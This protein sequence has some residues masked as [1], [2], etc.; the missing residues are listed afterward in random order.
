MSFKSWFKNL[1]KKDSREDASNQGSEEVV[2]T[3]FSDNQNYDKDDQSKKIDET[4][5]DLGLN[6]EKKN[7]PKPQK[8]NLLQ[9]NMQKHFLKQLLVL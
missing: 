6:S 7:K 4:K 9:K 1:F 3:Q 5:S 2:D 8:E